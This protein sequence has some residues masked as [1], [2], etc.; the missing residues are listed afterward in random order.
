MYNSY[1]TLLLH[2]NVMRPLVARTVGVSPGGL[3]WTLVLSSAVNVLVLVSAVVCVR[4][5]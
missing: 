1:I 4:I 3:T 5:E 2:V